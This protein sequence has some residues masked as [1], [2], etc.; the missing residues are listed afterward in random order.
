MKRC[1]NYMKV[2]QLENKNQFVIYSPSGIIFQS[3]QSVIAFFD[4]D[5]KTLLL[6][7][8]W[9]YSKTT[10]K[11]LYIFLENYCNFKLWDNIKYSNNKRKAI[12][13]A[14]NLGLIDYDKELE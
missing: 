6:G 8:D 14:I 12:Q 1:I 3:Y 10:L 5:T 4:K 7:K 13:D 2:E 9:N 11:H